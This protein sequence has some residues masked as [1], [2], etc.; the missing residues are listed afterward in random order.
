MTANRDL[1]D[2]ASL[3]EALHPWLNRNRRYRRMGVPSLSL[4]S[5]RAAIGGTKA[6]Q[7]THIG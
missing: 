6:A 1:K 2:F 4:A 7:Q 5:S 3:I